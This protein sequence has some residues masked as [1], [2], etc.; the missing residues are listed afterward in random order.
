MATLYLL[1]HGQASFMSDNYDKLSDLGIEQAKLLG[2]YF[3]RKNITIDAAFTGTMERQKDTYKHFKSRYDSDFAIIP[4]NTILSELNEHQFTEVFDDYRK[5]DAALMATI[6][7]ASPKKKRKI[8]MQAFFKA[9]RQWITEETGEGHESWAAFKQRVEA[10]FAQIETALKAHDTVAIFSSGGVISYMLG[11]ILELKDEYSMELNWQ[12]KK[13]GIHLGMDM[14]M[15]NQGL[16]HEYFLSMS[17][18]QTNSDFESMSFSNDNDMYSMVCENPNI[19]LEMS[20]VSP[21]FKN[22]EWRFA[23]NT[24]INRIDAISYYNSDGYGNSDYLNFNSYGNELSLES[25]LLKSVPFMKFFEVHGGVGTNI[26]YSFGNSLD[27]YGSSSNYTANQLNFNNLNEV[28]NTVSSPSYEYFSEYYQLN[29]GI[30]QR[31]FLQIGASVTVY[32]KIELGF[33]IRRG[34]GYRGHYRHWQRWWLQSHQAPVVR[35]RRL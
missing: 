16:N 20:L 6:E 19:R 11:I 12:I 9:Y 2:E 15:L 8:V 7:N 27:I 25:V 26:G 34:Y 17:K 13:A 22:T 18:E 29:N 32:N 10:G 24:I 33:D 14:D 31:A 1:R 28:S 35:L 21:Y 30:N 5:G 3:K 23:L 4:Q